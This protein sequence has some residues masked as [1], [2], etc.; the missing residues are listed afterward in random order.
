MRG[1]FFGRHFVNI[2][3]YLLT[4]SENKLS[5]CRTASLDLPC[6]VRDFMGF[7]PVVIIFLY[8]SKHVIFLFT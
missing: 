2:M 4:V 5:V 1:K 6:A 8:M 3:S 7:N